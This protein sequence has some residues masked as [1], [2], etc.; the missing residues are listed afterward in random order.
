MN[1]RDRLHMMPIITPAYPAFNS[2]YNIIPS[3][4]R[5]LKAELGKA[6]SRTLHIETKVREMVACIAS[7]SERRIHLTWRNVGF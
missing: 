6:V 7:V 4:L 1:P 2:S 5:I 3:T